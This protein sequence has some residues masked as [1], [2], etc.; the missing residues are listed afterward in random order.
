MGIGEGIN[1]DTQESKKKSQKNFSEKLVR[2]RIS[3]QI[4]SEG[5]TYIAKPL[6]NYKKTL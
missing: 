6:A 4:D 1:S 2:I 5:V 3:V